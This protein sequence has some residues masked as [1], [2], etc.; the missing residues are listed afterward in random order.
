MEK[1]FVIVRDEKLRAKA[2]RRVM[3]LDLSKPWKVTIAPYKRSRS[4]EQNALYWKVISAIAEDTGN[5]K[6]AVHEWVRQRFL[7]P[8][9]VEINGEV[10]ETRRSTTKL[11]VDEMSDLIDRVIA[12]AQVDLGIR[13][14]LEE[15]HAA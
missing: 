12:W 5:S 10:R 14:P 9:L 11:K 13:I 7:P 6:D 8:E 2:L 15:R 4:L 1:N 3:S